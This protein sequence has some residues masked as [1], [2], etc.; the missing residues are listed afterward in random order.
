MAEELGVKYRLEPIQS[1]TGE[2]QTEEYLKLNPRGKIPCMND[3]GFVLSESAAINSY[4]CDTYGNGSGIIP[5]PATKERAEYDMWC[6]FIMSEIDAQSLYMHRKHAG[7]KDLY[8]EAP[9][10]VESARM[11]F[12]KQIA[13]R[14]QSV[15]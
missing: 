11:Y 13:V 15:I 6:F 8:G 5:K 14:I 7:L 4:L 1:R 9:V 10:A 2:T 12:L 3:N